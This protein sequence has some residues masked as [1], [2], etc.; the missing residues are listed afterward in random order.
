[1]ES[2]NGDS[3]LYRRESQIDV[4]KADDPRG[5]QEPQEIHTTHNEQLGWT[6]LTKAV[7]A[8]LL[9]AVKWCLAPSTTTSS[10][11]NKVLY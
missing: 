6:K 2:D 10:L 7:L 4:E 5:K 1:M 9:Q 8:G 11:F 3:T